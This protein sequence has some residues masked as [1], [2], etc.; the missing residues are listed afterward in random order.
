[1]HDIYPRETLLSLLE[2]AANGSLHYP[3]D[4]CDP[5]AEN[6]IFVGPDVAVGIETFIEPFVVLRGDTKISTHCYIEAGARLENVYLGAHCYVGA[7]V[8][9]RNV[10]CGSRCRFV[11]HAKLTD[12]ELGNNCQIGAEMKRCRVSDNVKAV[13]GNTY[14]G[15][16]IIEN[17]VNIGAGV[18]TANYDGKE[19]KK[20][21]IGGRSFIGVGVILVARH[22]TLSIGRNVFIPAGLVVRHSVPS[23]KFL[24]PDCNE[25]FGYRLVENEVKKNSDHWVRTTKSERSP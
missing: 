7:G 25:P 12:V 21:F 15:D 4:L 2:W 23:G 22:P 14:L 11:A 3:D 16:T 18:I 13:H 20:T 10:T 19:K 5:N 17:G 6:T 1:M 8:Q 24:K 9:L